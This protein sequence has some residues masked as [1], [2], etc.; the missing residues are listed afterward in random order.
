M[1]LLVKEHPAAVAAK[2]K[3]D[4]S[5]RQFPKGYWQYLL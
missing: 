5:L 4:F 2:S 3:I 1:V